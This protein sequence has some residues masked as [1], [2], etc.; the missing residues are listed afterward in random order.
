MGRPRKIERPVGLDACLRRVLRQ[1][2][3]EDRMKIFREWRREYLKAN[4]KREPTDQEVED[5]IKLF[6]DPSFDG[7]N[8]P[9]GFWDSLADFVPNFHRD[10]RRKRAQIAA[11]ARWSK[12]SE[13]SS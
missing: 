3:P 9:F 13:K 6:R 8:C 5:E 7:A 10:N 12:K 2:R 4:L 11:A 1:K